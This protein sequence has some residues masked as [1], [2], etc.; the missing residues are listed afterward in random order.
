MTL[1]EM[2]LEEVCRKPGEKARD[3]AA[4][5]RVERRVVNQILY[6]DLAGQVCRDAN[7][8]WLPLDVAKQAL[9]ELPLSDTGSEVPV[10]DSDAILEN[11][12]TIESESGATVLSESRAEDETA[13]VLSVES[14]YGLPE[15]A[16]LPLVAP[17]V[18]IAE[19]RWRYGRSTYSIVFE[20]VLQQLA[21]VEVEAGGVGEA[22]EIAL[23]IAKSGEAC[24]ETRG[25]GEPHLF[26]IDEWDTHT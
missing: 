9:S 7:Y 22:E 14:E 12:S 1:A 6:Y 20:R 13:E 19:A 23:E 5:M 17:E 24:W 26:H 15:E 2:I 4:R 16:Q 3:I 21:R 11:H 18:A 25:W 10:V 8:R